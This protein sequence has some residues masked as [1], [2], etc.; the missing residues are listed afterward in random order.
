[1]TFRKTIGMASAAAALSGLTTLAACSGGTGAPL[2]ELQLPGVREPFAGGREAVSGAR[3]P[4]APSS[5]S[6]SG[7]GSGQVDDQGNGGSSPTADGGGSSPMNPG[8]PSGSGGGDICSAK[9][10]CPN[11]KGNIFEACSQLKNTPC[12]AEVTAYLSCYAQNEVCDAEGETDESAT[13]QK[14][15]QSAQAYA[16]CAR[17]LVDAG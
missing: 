8:T 13:V 10:K 15:M 6:G 5:G 9:S 12:G 4:A 14:C 11:E 1:M 17:K 7:S 2:T 16:T 3:E